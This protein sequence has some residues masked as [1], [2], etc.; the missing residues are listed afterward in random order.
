[1]IGLVAMLCRYNTQKE[2][3]T[4]GIGVKVWSTG[5][6]GPAVLLYLARK[7]IQNHS[8]SWTAGIIQHV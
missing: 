3:S 7:A 1:M 2:Q 4:K 8:K 6:I 5:Q